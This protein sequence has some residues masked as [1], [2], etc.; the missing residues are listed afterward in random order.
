MKQYII[1]SMLLSSILLASCS[2][3]ET[4]RS[5]FSEK[6]AFSTSKLVY[7]NS[8]ANVYSSIGNGLY[9]SDGGSVH[10]FQEFSSDAS[11]IPGRQGDW[12]DGGAWQNIFLHNFESSVSSI[13]MCGTTCIVSSVLPILLS[14]DSTSTWVSIRSMLTT[15]MS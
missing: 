8:V 13:T 9:G 11:M 2:L 4:P 14:T 7:V 12:V 15:F 1:G 10:T 5:K 3:D 6:E